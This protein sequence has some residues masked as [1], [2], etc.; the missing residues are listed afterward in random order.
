MY[1]LMSQR[2]AFLESRRGVHLTVHAVTMSEATIQYQLS[3]AIAYLII[4]R[5]SLCKPTLRQGSSV[6]ICDF[7]A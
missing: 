7:H 1:C 4:K 3:A 2:H 5:H 6:G